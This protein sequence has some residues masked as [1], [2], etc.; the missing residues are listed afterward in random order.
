VQTDLMIWIYWD[1]KV[2]KVQSHINM[3]LHKL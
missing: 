3:Y 1:L 2:F